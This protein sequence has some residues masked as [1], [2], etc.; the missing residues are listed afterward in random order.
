MDIL[1]GVMGGID[2]LGGNDKPLYYDGSKYVAAERYKQ[3][4]ILQDISISELLFL[5]DEGMMSGL[6]RMY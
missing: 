5:G 2:I 1:N 6:R 3:Y 4:S